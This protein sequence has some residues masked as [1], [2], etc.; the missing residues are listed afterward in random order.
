[1]INF[2]GPR[3]ASSRALKVSMNAVSVSGGT[4]QPVMEAPFWKRG[5]QSSTTGSLVLE[6]SAV[7]G[8]GVAYCTAG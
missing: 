2:F 7:P 6:A 5:P 1:M 8:R 3:D 4:W